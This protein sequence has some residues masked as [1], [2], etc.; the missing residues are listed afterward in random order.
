MSVT[1]PSLSFFQAL[2]TKMQQE[3]TR[4]RHLGLTVLT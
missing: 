4:F 3:E 2:Q 1:F